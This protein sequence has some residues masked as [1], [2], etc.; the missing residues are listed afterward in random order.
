MFD[1]LFLVC[2]IFSSGCSF[3]GRDGSNM[4][5]RFPKRL[6]TRHRV[7]LPINIANRFGA[8]SQGSQRPAN[9]FG[10]ALHGYQR[11]AAGT[12]TSY[13]FLVT[14]KREQW[15]PGIPL[16][17]GIVD[18]RGVSRSLWH[19]LS[20]APRL[21]T[22]P[23]TPTLRFWFKK[24]KTANSIAT[25]GLPLHLHTPKTNMPETSCNVA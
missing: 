11:P 19:A 5:E 16:R 9:R 4:V 3:I 8:A 22:G 2:F 10:A 21:Y 12:M 15:N 25:V 20:L 13:I 1:L 18:M 7:P 17:A 6:G 14:R 24:K 23:R